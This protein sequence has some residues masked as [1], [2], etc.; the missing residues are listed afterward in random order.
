MSTGSADALQTRVCGCA[1]HTFPGVKHMAPCCANTGWLTPTNGLDYLR[2]EL[3]RLIGEVERLTQQRDSARE[4]TARLEQ[5]NAEALRLA[6]HAIDEDY[7][8]S[9]IYACEEIA[10]ILGAFPDDETEQQ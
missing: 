10:R 2:A 6:Q 4:W 5:Q 3:A 9:G 8:N 1:C 7:R